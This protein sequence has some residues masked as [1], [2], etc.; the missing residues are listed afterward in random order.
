MHGSRFEFVQHL[1][2]ALF[3]SSGDDS[4]AY[5]LNHLEL[6]REA[7]AGGRHSANATWR[8]LAQQRVAQVRPPLI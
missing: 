7:Q 5:A 8:Q 1:L 4:Q 3:A 6:L 2:E